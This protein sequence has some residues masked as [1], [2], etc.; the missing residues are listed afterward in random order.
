MLS[1]WSDRSKVIGASD[2]LKYLG[3]RYDSIDL[4]SGKLFLPLGLICCRPPIYHVELVLQVR[5][6]WTAWLLVLVPIRAILIARWVLGVLFHVL[7]QSKAVFCHVLP[8]G[9]ERAGGLHY[10]LEVICAGSSG[11]PPVLDC[12]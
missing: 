2:H 12:C 7:L 5:E 3:D 11:Q 10:L 1:G 6:H 4:R 8:F 9:M